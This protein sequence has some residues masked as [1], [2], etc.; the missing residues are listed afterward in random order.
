MEIDILNELDEWV[1]RIGKTANEICSDPDCKLNMSENRQPAGFMGSNDSGALGYLGWA[2]ERYLDAIPHQLKPIF[3][4]I[5]NDTKTRK[6]NLER[7]F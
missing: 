7:A 3:Q 4:K 6:D 1:E 5:L 2:I